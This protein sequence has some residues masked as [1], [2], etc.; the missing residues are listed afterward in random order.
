MAIISA[1]LAVINFLPFPI[2][3][4]GHV[5][6]LIA[7]KIRKRPL[8]LKVQKF[9]QMAGLVLIAAIFVMITY[10]DIARFFR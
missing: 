8:S 4:G 2:V 6:F 3:D 9:M 10:N 1:N 5:V 7:E